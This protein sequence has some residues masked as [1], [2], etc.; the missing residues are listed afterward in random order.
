MVFIAATAN[1]SHRNIDILIFPTSYTPEMQLFPTSYPIIEN[2][3]DHTA[4]CGQHN[5]PAPVPGY[6][7]GPVQATSGEPAPVLLPAVGWPQSRTPVAG[8]PGLG[9]QWR[10]RPRCALQQWSSPSPGFQWQ[11]SP[12]P[13][14]KRQTSPGPGLQWRTSPG[15]Q[16]RT[17][18]SCVVLDI[19]S[20]LS[21]HRDQS[22]S[23]L[24]SAPCHQVII[25]FNTVRV[26]M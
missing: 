2:E 14:L 8:H 4:A 5:G 11:T 19:C 22:K 16:W 15:L 3:F 12:G 25:D 21:T 24:I 10:T 1:I 13:S 26:D 17:S 6:S 18:P 20:V 7:G 9:L 23:L